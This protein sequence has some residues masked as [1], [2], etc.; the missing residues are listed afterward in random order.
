MDKTTLIV[1]LFALAGAGVLV[2]TS[3]A[4]GAPVTV[5]QTPLL[6][7]K[8]RQ[9]AEAIAYAEGF[10]D[11]NR[12][13]NQAAR[14]AR[15]NNPGDIVGSGDAGSDGAYRKYSTLDLGWNAI[16][17]MLRLDFSGGSS[18]YSPS[19]TISDYAW[20][21]TSTQPDAWSENVASWLGVPRDTK[22]SDWLVS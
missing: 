18:I 17:S 21:Y 2:L 11:R 12:T 7:A 10:W 22:I 1:S 9:F 8:I 4:S 19:M 16:Y 15:N 3:T 6:E 14:P 13:V 20:T 5:Q